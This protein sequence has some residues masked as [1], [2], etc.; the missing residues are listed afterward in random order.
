MQQDPQEENIVS[1]LYDN[2]QETQREIMEIEIKK[3]RNKLFTLAAMFFIS[4]FIQ[5]TASDA[6]NFNTLI[7][8][9]VIPLIFVG[10]AFLTAKEPL[11]AMI[12]CAVIIAAIWIYLAVITGGLSAIS[13]LIIKGVVVYLIIAGFQ[14]AIEAQKIK[15]E[16][17]N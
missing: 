5:L 1:G 2:Y 7:V 12:I 13:G 16:L 11:L 4:D 9:S 8:I 10:L 3:T 14:S 6:L 15:K 17:R